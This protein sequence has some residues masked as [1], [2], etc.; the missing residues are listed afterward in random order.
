MNCSR[1]HKLLSVRAEFKGR[2]PQTHCPLISPW[3]LL[4]D[5][6]LAHVNDAIDRS[7]SGHCRSFVWPRLLNLQLLS[8]CFQEHSL[9]YMG[10]SLL[11]QHPNVS[12]C[13]A[14]DQWRVTLVCEQDP[15]MERWRRASACTST[16]TGRS[17][18]RT[19]AAWRGARARRTSARTATPPGGTAPAASSSSRR[20]AG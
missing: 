18:R 5:E 13:S 8:T 7:R 15:A 19:A 12:S 16:S 20:A 3:A 2:S 6:T 9:L 11:R 14:A 1:L 17:R 10:S 4:S